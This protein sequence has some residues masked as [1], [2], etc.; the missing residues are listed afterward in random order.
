MK[1]LY[2]LL[3]LLNLE[4]GEDMKDEYIPVDVEALADKAAL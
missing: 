3:V 4:V 1:K 2:K